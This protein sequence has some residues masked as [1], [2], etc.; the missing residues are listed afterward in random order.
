MIEKLSQLLQEEQYAAVKD[1]IVQ[2]LRRRY[3]IAPH[4][5]ISDTSLFKDDLGIDDID[6]LELIALIEVETGAIL[7]YSDICYD[8]DDVATLVNNLIKKIN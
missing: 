7:D 3:K 2:L 5:E 1:I 4:I 8:K 6:F